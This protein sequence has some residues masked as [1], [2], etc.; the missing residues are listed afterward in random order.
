MTVSFR[1]DPNGIVL[2]HQRAHV[3]A[4]R[5][6]VPFLLLLDEPN[7]ALDVPTEAGSANAVGK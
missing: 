2:T 3:R 5:S 1:V 4:S 7:A 6:P